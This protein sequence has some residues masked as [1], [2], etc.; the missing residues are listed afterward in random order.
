MSEHQGAA[1]QV[2]LAKAAAEIGVTASIGDKI[3]YIR[4][5]YRHVDA[6]DLIL[7]GAKRSGEVAA[8]A[9]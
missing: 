8:S 4:S 1:K 3:K 6:S 7:A 2:L 5:Y 9:R